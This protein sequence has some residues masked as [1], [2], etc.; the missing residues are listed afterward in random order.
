MDTA[1]KHP[2]YQP[3]FAAHEAEI[4]PLTSDNEAQ[5]RSLDEW[6]SAAYSAQAALLDAQQR[7]ADLAERADELGLD[8]AADDP[9]KIEL[10]AIALDA[11]NG[12]RAVEEARQS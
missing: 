3:K 8:L 1:F 11:D 5:R 10:S 4:I 7:F 9:R 12:R 2:G 6:I